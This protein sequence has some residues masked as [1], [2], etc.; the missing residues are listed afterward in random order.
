MW[1]CQTGYGFGTNNFSS[2]GLKRWGWATLIKSGQTLTNNIY[3]G[4]GQNVIE[5][6]TNVGQVKYSTINGYTKVKFTLSSNCRVTTYH[7]YI[8]DSLPTDITAN[9]KFPYKGGPIKGGV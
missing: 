8:G 7:I 1:N 4:A 2:F 6:S 9:G 5:K 3:A